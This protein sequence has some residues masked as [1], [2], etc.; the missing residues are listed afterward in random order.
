MPTEKVKENIRGKQAK[1]L[2]LLVLWLGTNSWH[3]LWISRFAENELSQEGVFM[4]L[5]APLYLACGTRAWVSALG[6]AKT[7]MALCYY[8]RIMTDLWLALICACQM[9]CPHNQPDNAEGKPGL[10]WSGARSLP[11]R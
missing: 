5:I 6:T 11:C 10:Q 4:R 7:T 2:L 9:G 3:E 1:H 8:S